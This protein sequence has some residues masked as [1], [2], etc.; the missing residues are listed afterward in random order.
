M[1][2]LFVTQNYFVKYNKIMGLPERTKEMHSLQQTKLKENS[3]V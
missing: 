3:E 1:F 2:L